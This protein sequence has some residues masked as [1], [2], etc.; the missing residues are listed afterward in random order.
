MMRE[1]SMPVD[2]STPLD[3][4][5]RLLILAPTKK[6]ALITQSLLAP[7]GISGEVCLS[8]NELITS[9]D[10]GAAA[11]LIAEEWVSSAG[12]SLVVVL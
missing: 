5:R 7:T 4:D 12:T 10:D 11:I 1:L 9:L 6:D 2:R 8:L 3:R